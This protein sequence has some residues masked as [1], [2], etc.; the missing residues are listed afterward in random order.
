MQSFVR[1]SSKSF[2]CTN[3]SRCEVHS[4]PAAVVTWA[5]DG[6]V[7]LG[8]LGQ[9]YLLQ[10]LAL[11]EKGFVREVEGDRHTLQVLFVD[12]ADFTRRGS[13]HQKSVSD[14]FK[15]G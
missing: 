5:K 13:A 9:S 12:F 7:I 6:K 4:S 1:F 3:P 14:C 10:E 11:G 2:G 8:V 15:P